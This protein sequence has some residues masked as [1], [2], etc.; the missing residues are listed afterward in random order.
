MWGFL[1]RSH[2]ENLSFLDLTHSLPNKNNFS[3][4]ALL[5]KNNSSNGL[6]SQLHGEEDKSGCEQQSL[7]GKAWEEDLGI[8]SLFL[9]I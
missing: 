9:G 5:K 4:E 8:G 7:K 2:S 6:I 3:L 1:G